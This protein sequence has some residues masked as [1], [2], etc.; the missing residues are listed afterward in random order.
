[1]S[2]EPQIKSRILTLFLE[3]SQY[4]ILAPIIRT[5][6]REEL[7]ARG[8]ITRDAFEDETRAKAQRSQEIEGLVDPINQEPPEVWDRRLLQTRD[9]LTDFYFAY[10][11]PHDLFKD[12]VQAVVAQRNPNQ[13]VILSFHPELAPI[14]MVLAQGEQYENLPETERRQVQHHHQEMIVVLLKALIS[15]QL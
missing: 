13:K 10:N 12:I 3:L 7:F 14:D 6:M 5:R 2:P 9:T 8:I 4:P 15:D 1:M 11:L